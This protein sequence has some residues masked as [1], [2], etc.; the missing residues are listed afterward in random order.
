VTRAEA[1]KTAGETSA[2]IARSGEQKPGDRNFYLAKQKIRSLLVACQ[3]VVGG[4]LFRIELVRQG[5]RPTES[6]LGTASIA[7]TVGY[8]M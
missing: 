6:D 1:A 5:I 7:F 8:R 3:A 4:G 2:P